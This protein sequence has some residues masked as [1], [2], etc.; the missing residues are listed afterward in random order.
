MIGSRRTILQSTIMKKLFAFS[1]ATVLAIA[2]FPQ[3]KTSSKDNLYEDFLKPGKAAK[4]RVWWHWMNGNITKDGI[5]KDLEW[6]VRSG[7]GGFQN[8]DANL[9]TPLVLPKKIGFMKPDWKDAFRFTTDL[10]D[11]LGLEM[12]IAGSPGWS[13][14]EISFRVTGKTPEL[15]HPQTGKREKISYQIKDGR[16]IIPLKFESWDLFYCF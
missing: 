10:A 4:P 6:M 12:A 9:F 14:A 2:A 8:F 13:E 7:I 15:W 1:A 16:T 3:T 11:K 5:Q